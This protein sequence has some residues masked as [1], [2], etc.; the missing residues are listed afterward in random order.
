MKKPHFVLSLIGVAVVAFML[1]SLTTHEGYAVDDIYQK[2][3]L[4]SQ[5][6]KLVDANYVEKVDPGELIYGAIDGMLRSLDPH[7]NFLS[8]ESFTQMSEDFSG[9]FSGIGIEFDIINEYLTV[10]AVI[11]GSPSEEVGLRPGDRITKINGESSIGIKEDEVR[12]KLRGEKGTKVLVTIERE[13]ESD[14]VNLTITRNRVPI[15]SI[16]AAFMLDTQTGYIQ[17]RRFAKTTSQD[18][19]DALNKLEGQGMKRLVLDLRQN[20][21]GYLDQAVEVTNKFI[22][23][24]KV[25]VSTRGRTRTSN[26]EYVATESAAHPPY[27]LIVLID[28]QTASASEI[29]AGAIQ[30]WDRGLIVGTRSFGKGLVQSLF[31][32]P[33]LR[34]GSALKLTT[35]KYYTPSG[36]LIQREYKGKNW[37]DYIDE[38]FEDGDE[39]LNRT[40]ENTPAEAD[41]AQ[42]APTFKTRNLGRTV[43]GGGGIMPDV[44][45]KSPKRAYPFA[46]KL[47]GRAFFEFATHYA[48]THRD[49]KKDFTT[50]LT[51]FVVDDEMLKGFKDQMKKQGVTFTEN[52]FQA[53]A[54]YVKLQLKRAIASNLWGEEEGYKV[55]V[56][57]DVQLQEGL[58]LFTTHSLLVNAK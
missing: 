19:E 47:R 24:G 1:G 16:K 41:S 9:Q 2:I 30:D 55:A 54:D 20:S 40:G 57:G 8:K 10:I 26:Q 5:V 42:N 27:P 14:P 43:Y 49:L 48:A 34:D 38:A 23:G 17:L 7:S 12:A 36:R 18:L 13:G 39:P 53:D 22:N 28:H 4:F 25:I 6:L 46:S 11:E 58:K 21:G 56:R 51:S 50:F 15:R 44:T 37:R 3:G 35:A 29:V 52:D 32:E 33:Y 45:V 31:T